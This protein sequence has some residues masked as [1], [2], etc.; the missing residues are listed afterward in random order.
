MFVRVRLKIFSIRV[1]THLRT[2]GCNRSVIKKSIMCMML[3][4]GT[5][6]P[7]MV[8]KWEWCSYRVINLG[9]CRFIPIIDVAVNFLL[10]LQF[11]VF[12]GRC[13]VGMEAA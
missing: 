1:A 12:M 4:M 11:F 9:I 10:F 5:N 3:I 8:P 7:S 13:G 2:V 6:W